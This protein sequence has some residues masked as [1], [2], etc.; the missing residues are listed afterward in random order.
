MEEREEERQR[1]GES[2]R[3]SKRSRQRDDSSALKADEIEECIDLS[4][5]FIA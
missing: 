2:E 5:A 3:E 4:A 1:E